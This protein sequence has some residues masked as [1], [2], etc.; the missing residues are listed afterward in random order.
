M[1]LKIEKPNKPK[2]IL[3]LEY[4]VL[5]SLQNLPHICPVYE[6][7]DFDKIPNSQGLNFIIMKMLGKSLSTVKHQGLSRLVALELLVI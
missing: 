1:A 6:F 5:K 7:I 2:R 3:A 4:Q